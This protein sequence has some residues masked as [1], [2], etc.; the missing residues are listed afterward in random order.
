M[1]ASLE[2]I[3]AWT[4]LDNYTRRWW[5]TINCTWQRQQTTA[6]NWKSQIWHNIFIERFSDELKVRL[7]VIFSWTV[8]RHGLENVLSITNPQFNSRTEMWTFGSSRVENNWTLT[9]TFLSTPNAFLLI[10]L[11]DWHERQHCRWKQPF[12][13][14]IQCFMNIESCFSFLA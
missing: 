13:V 10:I 11:I 1:P 3:E 9:R 5:K 8:S 4:M 6:I 12:M 14:L 7:N 2:V